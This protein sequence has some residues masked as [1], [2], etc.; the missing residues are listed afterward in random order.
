MAGLLPASR[1]SPVNRAQNQVPET[2]QMQLRPANST[3]LILTIFFALAAIRPGM[4]ANGLGS[5]V[6]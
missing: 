3:D 4:M 5:P 2:I 1:A 6:F